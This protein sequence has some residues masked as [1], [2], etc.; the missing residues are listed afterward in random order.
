MNKVKVIIG[1]I[2][3]TLLLPVV[4]FCIFS[5]VSKGRYNINSLS[6]T[7]RNSVQLIVLAWGLMFV[8]GSDM[9]DFSAGGQMYLLAMLVAPIC[10]RNNLGIVGMLAVLMVM[11]VT[12]RAVLGVVFNLLNTSALV[13]TLAACLIF[14]SLGQYLIKGT[15]E[16][17]ISP[18]QRIAGTPEIFLVL[19]AV[20]AVTFVLWNWTGFACHVRA[21]G[22]GERVAKN[23]SLNPKKI[24]FGVFLVE[25]LY[26]GVAAGIM[27]ASKGSVKPVSELTSSSLVFDG[28]MAVFV[29]TAIEKYSNRIIGI[30]V[31]GIV[32]KIINSGLLACGV[33]SAWQYTVTGVAL[34]VFIGYS[35]NSERI[36]KYFADRKRVK[37]LEARG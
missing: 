35:T 2:V 13:V 7:I 28:L 20:M 30:G 29:G 8:M 33:S 6:M 5:V 14:E 12:M 24:R 22:A 18:A 37:E 32:I 15:G 21:L 19:F 36:M 1:N 26:I 11:S 34:A 9:W 16:V 23:I 3:K 10:N 4:V 17:L 31:G 25:G 27:L